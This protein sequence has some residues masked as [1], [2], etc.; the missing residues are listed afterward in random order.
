MNTNKKQILFATALA[1]AVVVGGSYLF[2]GPQKDTGSVGDGKE[3]AE[4]GAGDNSGTG[5]VSDLNRPGDGE[6]LTLEERK[7]NIEVLRNKKP[8]ELTEEDYQILKENYN[9]EL[10]I[11]AR[12]TC[13]KVWRGEE[14]H[15]QCLAM[16]SY[17]TYSRHC[18]MQP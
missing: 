9:C 7:A 14:A 3:S 1:V 2:S 5:V 15:Q 10:A 4:Q 11:Q 18:G 16:N 8:S 13:E 17:F 6:I 12:E